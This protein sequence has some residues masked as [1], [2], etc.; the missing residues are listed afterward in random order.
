MPGFGLNVS[1]NQAC[2]QSGGGPIFVCCE[3]KA[4]SYRQATR[5]L[6]QGFGTNIG[7]RRQRRAVEWLAGQMRGR[8][9]RALLPPL[10]GQVRFGTRFTIGHLVLLGPRAKRV[11][12]VPPSARSSAERPPTM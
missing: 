2:S 9:P 12:G 11:L 5:T 7:Y 8:A 4:A 10:A 3:C 6:A 1:Q